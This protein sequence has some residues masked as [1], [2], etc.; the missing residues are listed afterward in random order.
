MQAG[1]FSQGSPLILPTS[2]VTLQWVISWV[3]EEGAPYKISLLIPSLPCH[4]R[5]MMPGGCA[6]MYLR[7]DDF[8]CTESISAKDITHTYTRTDTHRWTS[9]VVAGTEL[10]QQCTTIWFTK[11]LCGCLLC[12]LFWQRPPLATPWLFHSA[13]CNLTPSPLS[14]RCWNSASWKSCKFAMLCPLPDTP[15]SESAHPTDIWEINR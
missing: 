7:R 1:R 5:A 14:W 8:M 11:F 12:V 4:L 6:V 10:P 9:P 15:S 2:S 3:G 13:S